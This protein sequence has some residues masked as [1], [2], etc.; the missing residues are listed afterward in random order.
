MVQWSTYWNQKSANNIGVLIA[1]NIIL[2][3]NNINI[4]F[5]NPIVRILVNIF[6]LLYLKFNKI[7]I[8]NFQI[9]IIIR[10]HKSHY[11]KDDHKC[12]FIILIGKFSGGIIN[13]K[14]SIC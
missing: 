6:K 7:K 8:K 5:K 13:G 9:N 10:L 11:S 1:L 2:L 4:L 14:N 12:L 3:N